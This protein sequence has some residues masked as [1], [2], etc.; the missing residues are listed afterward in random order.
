MSALYIFC[1]QIL[2]KLAAFT[3]AYTVVILTDDGLSDVSA[4]QRQ[5]YI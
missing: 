3:E 5:W 1:G 2:A 4:G